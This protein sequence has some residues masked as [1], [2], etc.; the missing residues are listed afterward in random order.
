MA[1][2]TPSKP[3]V[4]VLPPVVAGLCLIGAGLLQAALKGPRIL[5]P[6]WWYTGA[7]C[8]AAGF[9]VG[10]SALVLFRRTGTPPDPRELP[11]GLITDGP[12]RVTRNPMYLGMALILLGI[13]LWRGDAL[14]LAAPAAFVLV[15]N[16][17]R[18]PAEERLMEE[19]FGDEFRKYRKKVRRW[20]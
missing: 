4:P 11:T 7:F 5:A 6:N 9:F 18:I 8:V 20:I 17:T 1:G 3:S 12:F 19:L 14:L 13:A 15:I 2:M 10:G 16:F